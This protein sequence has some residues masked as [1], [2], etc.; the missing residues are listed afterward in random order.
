MHIYR[1]GPKKFAPDLDG[2]GAK[3]YGGRWNHIG[4]ACIYA[5]ASRALS[6]LE[7][8]AHISLALFKPDLVFTTYDVNQDD[9]LR[10]DLQDLPEN[11][12]S[13]PVL[14]ESM[15]VG[16]NHF[17][18]NLDS[19]GIIVPSTIIPDELNYIINPLSSKFSNLV[20]LSII[21]H[22]FDLR[23]IS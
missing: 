1:L 3:L 23:V 18:T 4:T 20:V 16:T 14:N 2:V 8:S 5:S 15:S 21:D 22:T 7:Y 6:M 17:T 9:F 12:N 10:I 13:I 11:W 19:L